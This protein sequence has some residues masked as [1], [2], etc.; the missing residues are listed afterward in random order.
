MI[1][2][3]LEQAA[4]FLI[5][6]LALAVTLGPL[7]GMWIKRGDRE[8]DWPPEWAPDLEPGEDGLYADARAEMDQWWAEHEETT[9]GNA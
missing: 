1:P 9:D 2:H 7:I 3:W 4:A 8:P 6:W 5:L